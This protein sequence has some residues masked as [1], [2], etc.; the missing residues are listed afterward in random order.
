MAPSVCLT[1]S[2]MFVETA[3]PGPTLFGHACDGG[4]GQSDLAWAA[5]NRVRFSE[6]PESADRCTGVMVLFGSDTP[7]FAATS[8]G[9]FHCLILPLKIFAPSEGVRVSLATPCR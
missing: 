9:S 5:R 2:T 7:G 4:Y 8:A 3:A 6:V 1:S